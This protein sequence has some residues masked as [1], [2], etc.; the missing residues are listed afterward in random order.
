MA[1]RWAPPR[2]RRT[3]TPP[4]RMYSRALRSDRQRPNSRMSCRAMPS[5]ASSVAPERRREC[6][7]SSHSA[8]PKA[9][10][11]TRIQARTE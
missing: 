2:A 9:A 4:R 5:R 11:N 10:D 8:K 7:V 6:V 1:G 3:A